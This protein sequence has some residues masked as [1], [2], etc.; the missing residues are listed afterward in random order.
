M[1]MNEVIESYN[2]YIIN[3]PTGANYIAQCLREDDIQKALKGIKDFSEGVLWLSEA[4]YLF[5]QNGK[6]TNLKIVK[7]EEFLNE[8]NMGLER[9]DYVLVADMF[10]YEIAPFF[11]NVQV[12]ENMVQ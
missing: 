2:N 3:I 6:K 10:E 9:K 1:E 12:I 11:E 8:I 7:I 5:E 4:S